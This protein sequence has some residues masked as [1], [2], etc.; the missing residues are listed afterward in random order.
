[1]L[2]EN[3]NTLFQSNAE[4][5]MGDL[6]EYTQHTIEGRFTCGMFQNI[7]IGK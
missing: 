3:I 7:S 2:D 1:V 4:R 5:C 6:Q